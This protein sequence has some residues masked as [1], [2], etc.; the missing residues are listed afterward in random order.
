MNHYLEK[1]PFWVSNKGYLLWLSNKVNRGYITLWFVTQLRLTGKERPSKELLLT[2]LVTFWV[3]RGIWGFRQAFVSFH[4]YSIKWRFEL[5]IVVV[6]FLTR[7]CLIEICKFQLSC[8][9]FFWRE[10]HLYVLKDFLV[11]ILRVFDSI[12]WVS[13]IF[14]GDLCWALKGLLAANFY[15]SCKM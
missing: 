4:S 2:P 14:L 15:E 3:S 13:A 12:W 5:V 7:F 1:I 11:W 10:R 8:S 6:S 9:G